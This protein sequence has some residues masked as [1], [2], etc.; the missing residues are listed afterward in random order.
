V[1]QLI[2]PF[3][4]KNDE[5]WSYYYQVSLAYMQQQNAVRALEV[6]VRCL[7]QP[8]KWVLLDHRS[9]DYLAMGVFLTKKFKQPAMTFTFAKFALE[10]RPNDVKMWNVMIQVMK[11]SG[12]NPFQLQDEALQEI[13]QDKITPEVRRFI[14]KSFSA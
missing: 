6:L 5:T 14:A 4:E 7:K 13:I 10:L 11:S 8:M 1:R 2:E 12:M 3:V 9:V